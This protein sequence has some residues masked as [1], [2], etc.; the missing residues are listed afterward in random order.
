[1][2][3]VSV[4]HVLLAKMGHVAVPAISG[5]SWFVARMSQRGKGIIY[6]WPAVIVTTEMF[7]I[8]GDTNQWTGSRLFYYLLNLPE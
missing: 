4:T 2:I 6:L 1:M 7:K 3:H 5:T 8:E